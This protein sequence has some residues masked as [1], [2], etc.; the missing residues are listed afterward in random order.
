[1]FDRIG[2]RLYALVGLFAV[3]IA[4]LVAVV[5]WMHLTDAREDRRHEIASLVETA[6]G[7]LDTQ[8]KLVDAGTLSEAEGRAR[9][10]KVIAGLRYAGGN[11][12]AIM[13][14]DFTT[15]LNGAMP[16]RS[17]KNYLA[18][19][20]AAGKFYLR[21]AKAMVEAKGEAWVDYVFMK[22]GETTAT[23]KL[24]FFKR[25]Q[26]WKLTVT[27]GVYM[28][29]LAD[30]VRGGALRALGAGLLILLGI[31]AV[32]VT[33]TRGITRPL[34]ALRGDMLRLADGDDVAE[35]A[36]ADRK[37]EIGEMARAVVVFRDGALAR[38]QMEAT[39]AAEDATRRAH[40]ARREAAF[41]AFRRTIG[42]VVGA[43]S[44]TLD[45]LQHTAET[46]NTIAVGAT[47]QASSAAT[48]SETASGNV[49]QVA[50]AAEELGASVGEIGRQ[51]TQAYGV[52]AAATEAAARTNTR[53]A[54]LAEAAQKIGDVVGLIRAIAE[55]TNLLALNATI[56]AA[57]AGDAG[58]GFAVVATEVKSLAAQTAKATEDIAGQID[59]IQASTREAV[60]AI[61][62]IAATMGEI[63]RFTSAIASAVEQ[64][65]A[66]TS[67]I[68]S[69]IAHAAQGTGRLADTVGHVTTAV[70]RTHASAE[71]VLGVTAALSEATRHLSGEVDRLLADAA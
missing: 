54:A 52:V 30:R 26:P 5:T 43:V 58:R 18:N 20:D 55:Q 21:D 35:I 33:I 14:D 68:S 50:S 53:V 15:V 37:G 12:F 47:E 31:G 69:N 2:G 57:R 19:P 23:P 27:T 1:M 11:Y 70:A 38:R 8:R 61:G 39:Q 28:D 4:V 56:E 7:V 67:E 29:D 6:I 36:G 65:S 41:D 66:A 46:M 24:G 44:D 49:Q 32:A 45:R 40:G 16:D 22:P 63:S 59:G 25:Y 71:D 60:G 13:D 64:Q 9:A 10:L 42:T 3:G 51:V 34:A 62:E 48:V 17:G